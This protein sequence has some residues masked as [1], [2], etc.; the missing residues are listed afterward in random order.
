MSPRN[1]FEQ[2]VPVEDEE[3]REIPLTLGVGGPVVG[4]VRMTE[5]GAVVGE[6]TDEPL[7]KKLGNLT[8]LAVGYDPADRYR[9]REH[10]SQ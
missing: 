4:T 1:E 7:R 9:V 3:P 8:G 2:N 5:N 10:P 6:I